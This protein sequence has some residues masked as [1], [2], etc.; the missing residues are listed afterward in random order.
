MPQRNLES[1]APLDEMPLRT[2]LR[3]LARRRVKPNQFEEVVWHDL[4][5]HL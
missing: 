3:A 5:N 1:G 4:K 2:L